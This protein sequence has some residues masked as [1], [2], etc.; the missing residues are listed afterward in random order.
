MEESFG[1][2]KSA[3]GGF[4]FSPPRWE[5]QRVAQPPRLPLFAF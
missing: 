5:Q 1:W 4:H 3:L 2:T